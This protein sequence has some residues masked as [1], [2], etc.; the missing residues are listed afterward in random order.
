MSDEK[1]SD[2]PKPFERAVQQ[3][4]EESGAENNQD[5]A[6]KS[7]HHLDGWRGW[8]VVTASASSLFV[9]MGVIYSWGILQADLARKSNM[10]LTTL[11]FVGSLA[12]SFMTSICIFVGKAVRKFGYRETAIAGALLLGLGEFVSSW[13]THHL[14]A[15][16][17]THG[18]IFGVGGG[19]TILP[20]S[21]APLQ[22]FRKRRG[23]ATGVVFGGGSLGA[24]V[25]GVATNSMV[26]RIGA[27]WTF[28]VL[29]FMLWAVCLPAACLMKQPASTQNSVPKLQWYSI[30]G[31]MHAR[32]KR[33]MP[34]M[35][36][37]KSGRVCTEPS[38]DPDR[39]IQAQENSPESGL[40]NT[41]QSSR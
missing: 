25:M 11:T 31:E 35:P 19:L 28:R 26:G 22:W 36:Q 40:N 20:C 7:D 8:I 1:P 14:G 17:V 21:T 39:E 27:P 41:I 24:A 18:V 38:K 13:V 5:S 32:W 6:M 2:R 10:S 4:D 16:F 12:T 9:F 23:L 30:Q 34:A 15:L 29:G 33:T 37:V 3:S